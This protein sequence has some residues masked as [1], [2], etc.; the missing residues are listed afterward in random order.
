MSGKASPIATHFSG[1]ER[2]YDG[3]QLASHFLLREFGLLGDAI[4]AFEGPC[5]VPLSRMVDLLDV[6]E[7]S[8][9][10]AKRMLHF[11]AEHFDDDLDRAIL[12]QHLLA[13]MLLEELRI[14]TRGRTDVRRR[15]ND[16]MVGDRKLSVSIATRSPVSTLLHLGV[17]V[18]PAGAPVPAIGLR[19]IGI[20]AESIGRRILERYAEE[21]TIAV[22][23]RAKVRPVT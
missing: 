22:R 11:I 15:G 19:E 10:R 23:S 4:V 16:L 6:R 8:P 21:R 12:R 13:A 20:G 7:R 5:R 14:A 2:A 3:R 1:A 17:N 18:D 9:I